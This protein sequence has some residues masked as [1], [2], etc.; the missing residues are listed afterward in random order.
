[1]PF[2]AQLQADGKVRFQLWAPKH[3]HIQLELLDT[4]AS[5]AAI[6]PMHPQRDGW[7]SL[8]TDRARAGTLYKY[9]LPDGLSVPDPASRFQPSDVHGP[10]EVIDPASYRWSDLRWQGRPWNEAVIYELHVGCFTEQGS[11]QA[12]SKRLDH[13]VRLGVTAIE[14]MPIGDFPGRRNW[15]YDGV[16]PFAPDSCYGGPDD[17]KAFVDAA[18]A[19]GL[20]LILDVVYNHF[21][22]EGN[23]LSAYAP[24]F[25]NARHQTPWGAAVNFDAEGNRTVREFVIHNALYWLEEFHIDGLR[26]DAVHAIRDDS[27]RHLLTELA[28]RVRATDLPWQ[29]HLIL[30]NEHNET[31]W[32]TPSL[33]SAQWNDDVH[34]VL[35]VAATDERRGYYADYADDTDKLGRA[36]AQGFAFQGEQMPYRG[37][38]RGGARSHLPQPCA[39]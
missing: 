14:V 11:F 20:M 32:L 17:F 21:G 19:R 27:D 7:H 13:L 37:S 9:R 8:L 38:A 3:D 15:G 10:S 36:L 6:L 29:V 5:V 34:H 26:L 31:T 4:A 25:F 22:P 23:Y 24:E 18:H 39:Q 1:M 28:Q 35:H 30:E 2:G 16:L 12:A 33:Y